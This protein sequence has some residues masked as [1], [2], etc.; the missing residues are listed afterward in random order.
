MIIQVVDNS[1]Q[2]DIPIVTV[3]IPCCHHDSLYNNHCNSFHIKRVILLIKG[4]M[5]GKL[6]CFWKLVGLIRKHLC[7]YLKLSNLQLYGLQVL[8]PKKLHETSQEKKTKKKGVHIYLTKHTYF[9]G[10][11][12]LRWGTTTTINLRRQDYKTGLL[13]RQ[14]NFYGQS[15]SCNKIKYMKNIKNYM[16]CV[17]FQSIMTTMFENKEIKH[18]RR[19]Y[20]NQMRS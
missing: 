13:K 1:L 18:H 10:V 2:V 20:T 19:A 16:N 9:K 14:S 8:I 5:L 4:D 17:S 15:M 3:T 6:L 12:K 11:N 7:P